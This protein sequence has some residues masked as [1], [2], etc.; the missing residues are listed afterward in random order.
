[1]DRPATRKSAFTSILPPA[2]RTGLAP[3][4]AQMV[5]GVEITILLDSSYCPSANMRTSPACAWLMAADKAWL[6]GT[7]EIVPAAMLIVISA[8]NIINPMRFIMGISCCIFF[9]VRS[10]FHHATEEVIGNTLTNDQDLTLV[11][12]FD[13]SIAVQEILHLLES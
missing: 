3:S 10:L 12:E 2:I 8:N 6:P 5:S 11:E 7:T 13:G 1:M 9:I 4:A